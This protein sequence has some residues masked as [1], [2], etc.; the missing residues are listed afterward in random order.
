M[1]FRPSQRPRRPAAFP[2]GYQSSRRRPSWWSPVAAWAG[3]HRVLTGVGLTGLVCI[4]VALVAGG[5]IGHPSTPSASTTI[6]SAPP[7]DIPT[8]DNSILP[9]IEP[10]LAL[11]ATADDAP[12]AT[13]SPARVSTT[14]TR[15]RVAPTTASPRPTVRPAT[16]TPVPATSRPVVPTLTATPSATVFVHAGDACSPVGATG[17]TELGTQLVCGT[18]VTSPTRP[19][20]HSA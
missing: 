7:A 8:V 2:A 20:W 6:T 1:A 14:P 13:T 3:T 9:P 4:A 11:A 19:R 15:P 18:T 17:V 5:L 10:P 16:T 12:P